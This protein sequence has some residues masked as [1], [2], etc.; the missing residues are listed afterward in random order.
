MWDSLHSSYVPST[1]LQRQTSTEGP[2]RVFLSHVH[3]PS[4]GKTPEDIA[5]LLG[6]TADLSISPDHIHLT[7]LQWSQ[8]ACATAGPSNPGWNPLS[9]SRPQ[10]PHS[11]L[12]SSPHLGRRAN[13]NPGLDGVCG[14]GTA[15]TEMRSWPASA[16]GKEAGMYLADW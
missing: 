15:E 4:L 10:A 14:K 6:R 5:N 1:P 13:R 12:H 16:M 11:N 2:V 3:V 7:D 8:R 9:W